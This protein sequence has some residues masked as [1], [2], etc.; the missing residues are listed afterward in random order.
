MTTIR[1]TLAYLPRYVADFGSLLIRPKRFIAPRN[2]PGEETWRESLLFLTCSVI[3][4]L[5]ATIPGRPLDMSM[6]PH[7][8]EEGLD[9][10]VGLFLFAVIIWTAWAMVGGRSTVRGF[11]VTFAYFG[12]VISVLFALVFLVADGIVMV[13]EPEMY[14]AARDAAELG[15]EESE[16]RLDEIGYLDRPA[17][18]TG[19]V[20]QMVGPS[21][22][23]AWALLAWGAF[24]QL[25]G[26]GEWRSC[27]A[28]L[29]AGF[30]IYVAIAAILFPYG[31]TNFAGPD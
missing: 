9:A 3:V 10:L 1:R 8:A 15:A 18:L 17:V 20:L 13:L 22:A 11:G 2:V 5:L 27:G 21:V 29:I 30:L 12:G 7:L 19:L 31:Q 16:R 6:V 4:T 14:E 28:L 26:L 23:P 24:R 25:N